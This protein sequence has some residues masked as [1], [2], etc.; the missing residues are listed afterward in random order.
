MYGPRG[1]HKVASTMSVRT[2]KQNNNPAKKNDKKGASNDAQKSSANDA[3]ISNLS[4]YAATAAF[5]AVLFG[6]LGTGNQFEGTPVQEA[7][8]HR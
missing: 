5:A 1:K 6:I 3:N 8:R 2:T 7:L 4:G